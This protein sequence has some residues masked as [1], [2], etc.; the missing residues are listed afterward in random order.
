MPCAL[1]ESLLPSFQ[2]ATEFL[3]QLLEPGLQIGHLDRAELEA[4][5]V[6]QTRSHSQAEPASIELRNP[7]R[8]TFPTANP[9]LT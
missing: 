4:H 9:K 7:S 6:Y 8:V 1:R 2:L 3:L 5:E